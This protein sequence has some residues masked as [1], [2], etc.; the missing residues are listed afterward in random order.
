MYKILAASALAMGLA[1][2]AFAQTVMDDSDAQYNSG[3]YSRQAV[4]ADP[5]VDNMTTQ[6]INDNSTIG[7]SGS[8]SAGSNEFCAPGT[9]GVGAQGAPLGSGNTAC[10]N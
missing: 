6:S 7:I 5:Y 9:P 4:P 1:T 2:S 10:N 3:T 8:S